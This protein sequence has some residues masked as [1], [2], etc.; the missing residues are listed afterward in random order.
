MADTV[1]VEE[2]ALTSL[3]SAYTTLAKD[4][5]SASNYL[6][7]NCELSNASGLLL[8]PLQP[9]YNACRDIASSAV[10]SLGKALSGLATQVDGALSDAQK[11][12]Q[13]NQSVTNKLDQILAELTQINAKLGSGSGG[14]NSG[15]GGGG[16]PS[17]G[18]GGG[19]PSG[20]GGG[21][22]PGGGGGGGS[23]LGG[24]SGG[25]SISEVNPGT[26]DETLQPTTDHPGS[27]GSPLPATPLPTDPTATGTG[28]G[29]GTSAGTRFTVD[30]HN[31][32]QD[33]TVTVNDD[34]TVTVSLD[35]PGGAGATPTTTPSAPASVA[36]SASAGARD[37]TV[38][39]G[40]GSSPD[41][42]VDGNGAG[43]ITV[44]GVTV[45]DDA[46]AQTDAASYGQPTDS[47]ADA[48]AASDPLGRSASEL[49]D[50]W[51]ARE[52]FT[53]DDSATNG[54]ITDS[55]DGGTTLDVS[56]LM[57]LVKQA[58]AN[59]AQNGASSWAR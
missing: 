18:G 17:G 15:G 23:H 21:G 6:S 14:G 22:Y 54:L 13:A 56:V 4:V 46:A 27:T 16:Y 25:S 53:F 7:A 3:K 58:A 32:D 9:A 29:S 43:G 19:Y 12:E 45:G 28:T 30:V 51:S 44:D 35:Q 37:V 42:S 59:T 57:G 20:G 39:V 2:S 24:T 5:T 33:E 52:T 47:Q 38:T 31:G 8:A 36:P 50:A 41:F 1:A 40:G 26:S 11:T 55:A 49:Q 48:M 34:G 10:A